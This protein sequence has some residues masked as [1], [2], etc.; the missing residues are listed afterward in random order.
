MRPPVQIIVKKKTY[1]ILCVLPL[2]QH[3][4]SGSLLFIKDSKPKLNIFKIF[5][6]LRL[7]DNIFHLMAAKISR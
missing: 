7:F 1:S 2:N 3:C 5:N 4:G 6:D